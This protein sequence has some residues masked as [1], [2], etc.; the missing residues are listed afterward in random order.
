MIEIERIADEG[1]RTNLTVLMAANAG[2]DLWLLERLI[3]LARW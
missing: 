1:Y 2:V 3:Y